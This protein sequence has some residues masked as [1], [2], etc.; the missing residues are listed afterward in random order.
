MIMIY[1]LT[2]CG[3]ATITYS[4]HQRFI[5][6]Q[7]NLQ[8]V[9]KSLMSNFLPLACT[10]IIFLI[11]LTWFIFVGLV[12]LDAQKLGF[13]VDYS[14]VYVIL[15][16]V[17]SVIMM[18]LYVNWSL[19]YVVVVVES[20]WWFSALT[21]SLYLV[22]GMRFVSMFIMLNFWGGVYSM[23]WS[24]SGMYGGLNKWVSVL[25]RAFGTFLIM[26]IWLSFTV[27]NTLLYSYCRVLRGELVITEVDKE[28]GC[29]YVDLPSDVEK[30]PRGVNVFVA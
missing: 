4:T 25:F 15:G 20:K 24:F 14:V 26:A 22:E 10:A 8:T 2:I 27:A 9:L 13:M 17:L 11:S 1:T 29:D 21:R 6:N 3:I 30:V 19:A 12:F 18:C 16:V 7:V 23:V 5:N 28:F